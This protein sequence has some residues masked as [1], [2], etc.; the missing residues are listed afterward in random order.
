MQTVHISLWI[1]LD[2]FLRKNNN[3]TWSLLNTNIV[4]KAFSWKNSNSWL[5]LLWSLKNTSDWNVCWAS[6]LT[7]DLTHNCIVP[8]Y[9][10][11]LTMDNAVKLEV[12]DVEFAIQ[13]QF[14]MH[15]ASKLNC[16]SSD[17]S[18][19]FMGVF[20]FL[21][22]AEHPIAWSEILIWHT[23][24]FDNSVLCVSSLYNFPM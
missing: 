21:L 20:E 24:Y 19:C 15:F 17:V 18:P 4:Y 22:K 12:V 9:C 1:N 10:N 6:F 7:V 5:S 2:S 11:R 23:F 16:H 13:F 14:K 8:L 3:V